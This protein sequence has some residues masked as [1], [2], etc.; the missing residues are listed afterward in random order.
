MKKTLFM[1]ALALTIA[2]SMVAGTMAVYTHADTLAGGNEDTVSA[3]KFYINSTATDKINIKLAPG[4][5][6]FWDFQV[7]NYKENIITEVP[8]D[9]KLKVDLKNAEALP[10]LVCT[11]Y[12]VDGDK[13][14]ALASGTRTDGSTTIELEK[15]G[16]FAANIK[17]DNTYKLGFYWKDTAG[18]NDALD[19]AIGSDDAIKDDGQTNPGDKLSGISVTVTGTQT[20]DAKI[21]KDMNQ[22]DYKP[23][24]K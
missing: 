1:G 22:P 10:D 4:N 20:T 19:T 21:L 12:R 16:E 9:L 6:E 14:V 5:E 3:K 15:L 11:L 18:S 8:M 2:T 7:T 17:K 23:A 13:N 24:N